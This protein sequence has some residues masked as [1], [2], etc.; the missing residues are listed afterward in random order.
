[1]QQSS[2]MGTE[3][4]SAWRC[5]ARSAGRG[6]TL[7]QCEDYRTSQRGGLHHRYIWHEAA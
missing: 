5:T 2:L 7:A 6:S 3:A 1:V 4:N